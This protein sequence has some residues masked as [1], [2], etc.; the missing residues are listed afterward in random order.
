MP[1]NNARKNIR[2]RKQAS[3]RLRNR[4]LRETVKA[5]APSKPAAAAKPA[6]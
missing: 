5:P 4:A 6:K 2:T 1:K 3:L